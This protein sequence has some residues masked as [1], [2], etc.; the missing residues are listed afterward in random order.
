MKRV[1]TGFFVTREGLIATTRYIVGG[2]QNIKVELLDKRVIDA[3]VVRSFPEYDLALLQ[4]NAKLDHLLSVSQSPNLPDNAPI[5]AVTHSGQG[6]RST[7]RTTRH[8]TAIHW[9]PTLIN[10]LKDAG[11][12]PIFTGTDNLLVGMLTKDAR[13]SS[14]YMYGLHISK[15]YQCVKQYHQELSQLTGN[16]AYCP[17]CGIMS[18]APAFGGNYCEHCGNTLPASLDINRRPQPHLIALYGEAAHQPCPNCGSQAGFYKK[19]CLRC[20]YEL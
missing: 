17:A 8:Q 18:R 19:D 2:E 1:G 11:G 12:N 5:I 16:S 10:H 14:G 7:K 9:F 4:V 13:R 3:L 15:I 20:G 6:L